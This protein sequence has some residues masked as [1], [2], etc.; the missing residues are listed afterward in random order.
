[1]IKA[2]FVSLSSPTKKRSS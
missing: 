1:M 2:K